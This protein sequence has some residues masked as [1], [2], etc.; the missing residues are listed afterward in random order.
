MKTALLGLGVMLVSS[1][2]LA[3]QSWRDNRARLCLDRSENNGAINGLASWI[4]VED[5]EMPIRGGQAACLYLRPG[6]L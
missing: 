4:R 1:L 3:A 2:S 5:Y 6:K